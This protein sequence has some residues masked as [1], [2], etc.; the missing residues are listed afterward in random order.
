MINKT[1]RI[2]IHIKEYEHYFK[3]YYFYFNEFDLFDRK[4]TKIINKFINPHKKCNNYEKHKENL[5]WE[6]EDDFNIKTNNY[7]IND[8][9]SIGTISNGEQNGDNFAKNRIHSNKKHKLILEK[10][11]SIDTEF[12]ELINKIKRKR[13]VLL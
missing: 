2:I 11:N 9:S 3:D 7:T 6:K 12:K 13:I 8:N 5:Y 10:D 1:I 4:N